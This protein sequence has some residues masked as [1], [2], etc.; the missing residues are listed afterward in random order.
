L[1]QKFLKL[2]EKWAVVSSNHLIADSKGIQS[3]LHE[4]YNL[5]A[6]F[7]AYGSDLFLDPNASILENY[8]LTPFSYNMLV[9]RMEPE[10]NIETILDGVVLAS[11][12]IPFIV[13]GNPENKFGK[14]L[15]DKY[16][17]YKYIQFIGGVYDLEILNNL[18]YYSRLYFH[19]HSVGG[20]N[21][22]L[23]EAMASSSFIAAHDNVFNKSILEEEALYFNSAL[24][25]SVIINKPIEPRKRE[26]FVQLNYQKVK[27][28][29][30]W[31]YIIQSYQDLFLKLA[32]TKRIV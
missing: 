6:T 14:Y 31:E 10:N 26:E 21:P 27:S 22:S 11:Q 25:V 8:N 24:D 28:K 2:A 13:I 29:Y 5:K 23:I 17:S 1:V 12:Q 4:K 19:G 9:A 7:I 15:V 30:S 3:Y 16:K 20:T 18:R 32:K